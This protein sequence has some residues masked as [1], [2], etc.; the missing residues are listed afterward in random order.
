MY[1]TVVLAAIAIVA[2]ASAC[3]Q[4]LFSETFQDGDTVGWSGEPG[5]GDI[6]LTE[7]A[8]N[9]SLRLQ[10]DAEATIR[11]V[12]SPG[13]YSI[14]TN[15]AAD[16][17]EGKDACVLEASVSDGDWME[18]GRISD[19]QDDAVSLHTVSAMITV[20]ADQLAIR[21]TA[22][23]C[24]LWRASAMPGS[25]CHWPPI[26]CAGIWPAIRWAL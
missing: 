17:L 25:A 15:F 3:A 10:R 2:V 1:R 19:G 22:A 21:I 14:S 13:R 24:G 7:Y 12:T 8:G 9:I 20:P 4:V 5:R 23:V 16:S 11:L 6:R 26:R 18:L